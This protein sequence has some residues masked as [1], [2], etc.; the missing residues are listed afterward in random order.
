V[1][2][3][4][5]PSLLAF[6]NG[7]GI[8]RSQ[9]NGVTWTDSNAGYDKDDGAYSVYSGDN[10]LVVGSYGTLYR[11]KR[12]DDRWE[13]IAIKNQNSTRLT[14]INGILFDR[15]AGGYIVTD[16]SGRI[17]FISGDNVAIGLNEGVL[18]HSEVSALASGMVNGKTRMY[19]LV[20]N[21]NYTDLDYDEQMTSGGFGTY[22]T[23]VYSDDN[24]KTWVK[25]HRFQYYTDWTSSGNT[26]IS[27]SPTNPNEVWV[28]DMGYVFASFNAGETWQEVKNWGKSITFD[29]KSGRTRYVCDKNPYKV[30][31]TESGGNSNPVKL[32]VPADDIYVNSSNSNFLLTNGLML[33]RDGGWT[34]NNI[35]GSLDRTGFNNGFS[36]TV[37]TF[38]GD[39]I[40][41]GLNACY[42]GGQYLPCNSYV[43][44]SNDSGAT[45]DVL[46]HIPGRIT[47]VYKNPIDNN[48]F[49][50]YYNSKDTS[51]DDADSERRKFRRIIYSRDNGKSWS[52]FSIYKLNNDKGGL[53]SI[54]A[55]KHGD[56]QLIYLATTSGLFHTNDYGNHWNQLG[57]LYSVDTSKVPASISP[58]N[59]DDIYT[60]NPKQLAKHFDKVAPITYDITMDGRYGSTRTEKYETQAK[61]K[62]LKSGKVILEEIMTKKSDSPFYVSNYWDLFTAT[63]NRYFDEL[64]VTPIYMDD[65]NI[66]AE[67][68]V[69]IPTRVT[70][71]TVESAELKARKYKKKKTK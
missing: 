45:W 26:A 28:H 5:K 67:G 17:A 63:A 38:D 35:I 46:K 60:L 54:V 8:Y 31:L 70:V 69:A 9:D 12:D 3:D 65:Q 50:V 49:V 56:S 7:H 20:R 52:P 44:S 29:P 51:G 41:G 68:E 34:W 42:G 58:P 47:L 59:S 53:S 27:V 48:L 10:E 36:F 30:T 22:K 39:Y 18:S 2:S 62:V 33:S 32:N 21:N 57:G 11:L 14:G 24:G 43:I 55:T 13:R 4:D 66:I 1:K 61:V 64:Q 40:L 16:L 15:N 19:A 71:T 37:T 25:R 23:V 6:S